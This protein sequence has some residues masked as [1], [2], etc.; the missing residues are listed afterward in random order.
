MT[1]LYCRGPR[2]RAEALRLLLSYV[3]VPFTSVDVGRNAFETMKL[4]VRRNVDVRLIVVVC[5]LM[6]SPS[7]TGLLGLWRLTC[8]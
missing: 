1:T 4:Q 5:V 2:G 3:N 8:V 6:S 7:S